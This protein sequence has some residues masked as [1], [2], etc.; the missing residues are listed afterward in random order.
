MLI[1]IAGGCYAQ[2]EGAAMA[3]KCCSML[4]YGVLVFESGLVPACLLSDSVLLPAAD[5]ELMRNKV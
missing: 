1:T 4:F 2:S 3:S 5:I